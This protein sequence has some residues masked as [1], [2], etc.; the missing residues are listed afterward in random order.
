MENLVSYTLSMENNRSRDL[1]E[2]DDG[3]EEILKFIRTVERK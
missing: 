1:W 2:E 3:G